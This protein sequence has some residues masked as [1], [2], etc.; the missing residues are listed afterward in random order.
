MDSDVKRA[1]RSF[2][3]TKIVRARHDR[4]LLAYLDGCGFRPSQGLCFDQNL[5]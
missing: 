2:A 3:K 1:F 5:P 4:E